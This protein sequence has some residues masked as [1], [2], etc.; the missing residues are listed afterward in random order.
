MS[1]IL[2]PCLIE[3]SQV[4]EAEARQ[5]ITHAARLAGEA[6][7]LGAG[8]GESAKLHC[9]GTRLCPQGCS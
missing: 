6:G 4:A 7:Y 9:D 1:S 8:H 2:I 3:S 5:T